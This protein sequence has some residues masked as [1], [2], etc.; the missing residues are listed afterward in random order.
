[1]QTIN[2]PK[3]KMKPTPVR[4]DPDLADRLEA[5]VR[6]GRVPLVRSRVVE[7][8]IR[9]FLDSEDGLLIVE[10]SRKAS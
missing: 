2:R 1:M 3:R 5:Y 9:Q 10:P 7:L 6:K 4:I 8:A